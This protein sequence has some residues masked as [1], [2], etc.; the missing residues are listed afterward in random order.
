MRHELLRTMRK[1]VG[2][3]QFRL[4]KIT[5]IS[6]SRIALFEQGYR[7]LEEKEQEEIYRALRGLKSDEVKND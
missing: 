2:I 4:E 6:R 5:G 3:S 1:K 7:E